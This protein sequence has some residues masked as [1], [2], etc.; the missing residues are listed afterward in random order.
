MPAKRMIP[1]WKSKRVFGQSRKQPEM[2]RAG[3]YARVAKLD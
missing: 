1:E 2:L 3:L